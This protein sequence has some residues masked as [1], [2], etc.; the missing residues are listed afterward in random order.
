MMASRIDWTV[1]MAM[2]MFSDQN[3]NYFTLYVALCVLSLYMLY[4][5]P[6]FIIHWCIIIAIIIVMILNTH[7][8]KR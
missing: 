7:T 5:E 3:N 6:F 1:S 4:I 2:K 8:V